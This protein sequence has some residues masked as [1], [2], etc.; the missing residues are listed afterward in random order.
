MPLTQIQHYHRPSD[1]DAA[2][3]ML[4]HEDGV[5]RLLGG[6]TDLAVR[7]PPEVTTLIDLSHAGLRYVEPSDDGSV[8]IGAMA[9]FTDLLEHPA[10][11]SHTGGVMGEMLAQV[12][13]VLHRNS[14]TIGGHVVRSRLSDVLP[15]LLALDAT[16]VTFAGSRVE[17]PLADYLAADPG[18]HVVVEVALPPPAVGSAAAFL[19]FTRTAFD[20]AIVNGCC[21]VDVQD[22]VVAGAR[23]VVGESSTVG[24]RLDAAEEALVGGPP[25]TERIAAAADL[26]RA[27]AD[28]HGDWIASAEYRT[29]LAGRVVQRCLTTVVDRLEGGTA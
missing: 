23:V 20:H 4:R 14:A 22:G 12:G 3:R 29:H 11:A 2:W 10:V 15:V 24:R 27:H 19:R 25:T 6:G 21:R 9:T 28:L 17:L 26:A 16:V 1:L 5:A 18:P 8:R 13:S 7:C